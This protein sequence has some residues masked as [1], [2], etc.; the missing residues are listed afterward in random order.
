MAQAY[1][2]FPQGPGIIF[3]VNGES[4]AISIGQGLD[5]TLKQVLIR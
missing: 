4:P 3:R 2:P 1:K 5:K